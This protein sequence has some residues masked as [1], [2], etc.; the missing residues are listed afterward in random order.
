MN[1]RVVLAIAMSAGMMLLVTGFFYQF[2]MSGYSAE[3][4]EV[5]TPETVVD[6]SDV[7]RPT[8]W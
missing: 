7:T 1:S 3:A 5:T 8:S 4:S 2:A 6:A